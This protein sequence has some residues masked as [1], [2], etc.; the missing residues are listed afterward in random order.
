MAK[1]RWDESV[2]SVSRIPMQ[3]I[4]FNDLKVTFI[5]IISAWHN[6]DWMANS[7]RHPWYEFNYVSHGAVYTKMKDSE[8]LVNAGSFFLIPPGVMHSHRHFNHTGDDGFCVRWTLEKV[9]I[10][11][12]DNFIG[13]GDGIIDAFSNF[14]PSS[15]YFPADRIF[16]DADNLSFPELQAAFIKWILEI[17]RILNP[18]AMN[19]LEAGREFRENS[20]VK[21]VLMYLEEYSSLEIDVNELADSVGYSYGHLARL[22]K[23]ETGSTII[24]KLNGIKIAKAIELLEHTDMSIGA[25]CGEVGF[26]SETYFSKLFNEYTHMSPSVFK[27]RYK[28]KG[29][30]I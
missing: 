26:N 20:I 11:E 8:F 10:Q 7:H 4:I 1:S 5:E 28:K 29:R 15:H 6:G 27:N 18:E 19:G 22:F 9:N 30:N 3:P 23:E 25:I 2:K 17:V 13:I 21:Q 14:R 24:E 12:P 16:D